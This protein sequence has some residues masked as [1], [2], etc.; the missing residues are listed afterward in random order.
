V[1]KKELK[2]G[3]EL[4][5]HIH[6]WEDHGWMEEAPYKGPN[7]WVWDKSKQKYVPKVIISWTPETTY[8]V[9]KQDIYSESETMEWLREQ[10]SM[11]T[12]PISGTD[13]LARDKLGN[14]TLKSD[15]ILE[16][17]MNAPPYVRMVRDHS[18]IIHTQFDAY[19]ITPHFAKPQYNTSMITPHFAKPKPTT[20]LQ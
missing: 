17:E 5:K 13:W 20:G 15:D 11:N 4:I 14:V 9:K 2:K 12:L 3:Q 1:I 19:M 16:K 8:E 6:K 10:H 18:G 7:G